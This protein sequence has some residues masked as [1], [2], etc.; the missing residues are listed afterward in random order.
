MTEI[1][2][3]VAEVTEVETTEVETEAKTFSQEE[4]DKLLQQESD[5]RV[6]KALET[7]KAKWEEEYKS[8]LET[9]KSE[10]ERL[11]TM[12]QEER[13]KAEI[14]QQRKEIED[15]RKQIVRERLEHQAIK[16][17]ASSSLPVNFSNYVMADTADEVSTNI[18]SF[19]K[20]WSAALEKAVEERL[21]GST[22]KS[23][24]KQNGTITK[25]Q[26]SK[27]DYHAR[28][29]LMNDDPE[30]VKQLLAK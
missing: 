5:R 11:A 24:N 18:K 19:Q 28:A 21:A 25:E 16:E 14:E 12:T 15:E 23:S 20:E 7:S 1:T 2:E 10:A 29:K 8:K 17:L 30:M 4:V 13:F 26:F 9:E 27:M 6:S 3:Q 22:P